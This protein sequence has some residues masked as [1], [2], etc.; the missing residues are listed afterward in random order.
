MSGWQAI[1]ALNGDGTINAG[2]VCFVCSF[3][4]IVNWTLLQICVAVLL[5]AFV[6]ARQMRED[7]RVGQRLEDLVT[8]GTFRSALDPLLE[9]LTKEYTDDADL[10]RRLRE[11]FEVR[12][13]LGPFGS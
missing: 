13:R 5:D 10:S 8:R 6:S 4:V 11:L 2:A 9:R 7:E 12:A 1:P 3:V